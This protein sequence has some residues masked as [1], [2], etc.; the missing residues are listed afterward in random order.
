MGVCPGTLRG[1]RGGPAGG[2]AKAGAVYVPLDPAYPCPPGLYARGRRGAASSRA[3][4][5]RRLLSGEAGL[6]RLV[7]LDDP[8]EALAIAARPDTPPRVAVAP[9]GLAYVVYTSGSTGRPKGVA[10]T[11]RA[12]NRLVCNTDYITLTPA[13][14]MAHA[15]NLSFDAATF[16]LWGALIHGARLVVV[17]PATALSPRTWWP[18][19]GG[20]RSGSCSSPQLSSTSSRRPPRTPSPPCAT[21]AS[22]G[23]TPPPPSRRRCSARAPRKP[24]S[25]STAPPSAPPSPPGTSWKSPR[26]RRTI[27]PSG[28]PSPTPRPTSWMPAGARAGRRPRRAVPGRR[29]PRPGYLGRPGRRRLLRASPLRGAGG[30]PLPHRRPRPLAPLRRAGWGEA[31]ARGLEFLGRLDRQVKIRGHRIEPGE[32]EA[33]LAR[34]PR[35][36]AAAVL[37][38]DGPGGDK[39]L[40]AYLSPRQ[41]RLHPRQEQR[42]KTEQKPSPS[43]PR[44]GPRCGPG[45]RSTCCPARSSSWTPC[46]STP[47]ARSTA[48]RPPGPQAPPPAYTEGDDPDHPGARQAGSPSPPGTGW[49]WSWSRCGTKLLEVSPIGVRDNF[50]ELGGHSLLALRLVAE[51]EHRFEHH[52]PLAT[53]FPAVTVET[54]AAP[55]ARPRARAPLPPPAPCSNPRDRPHPALLRRTHRGAA[56]CYLALSRH[57]APDAPYALETPPSTE[58]KH[59][60]LPSPPRSGAASPRTRSGQGPYVA[61]GLPTGGIVAFEMARQHRGPGRDGG[62]GA[63]GGQ[64]HRR[65]W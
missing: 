47:T 21:S 17:D 52:I 46:P 13:D 49:S 48:A 57:W 51:V 61:R 30:P 18:S 14:R 36:G 11:H 31:A 26:R 45:C 6:V 50:F 53:L 5:Q 9:E 15:S 29:R 25:T 62:G 44:C 35:V 38:Q 39:R 64:R 41:E 43:P 28:A 12:I 60:K 37:V 19:S 10:V 27:S 63:A 56:T 65:P 58:T 33:T 54:V 55:C 34:H 20:S 2:A 3:G 1:R 32:V 7:R 42:Q 4:T 22:G 8:L 40:V 23:R 24:C 16:E 59:P